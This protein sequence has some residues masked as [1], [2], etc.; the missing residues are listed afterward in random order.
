MGFLIKSQDDILSRAIQKIQS[1]TAITSVAPGSIMRSLIEAIAVEMGDLYKVV[2]FN[3]NLSLVSTAQGRALDLMAELYGLRR[4]TLGRIASIDA[5]LGSFYFYTLEAAPSDIV[6][7]AGTRIFTDSTNYV[8]TSFTYEL[9]NPCVIPAGRTRAYG[10]IKPLF[11]DSIFTAGTHT[12][13][14]HN[15]T[16]VPVGV[17][18]RCTNPKVIPAQIGYEDD[19][20]FRVRIIKAVRTTSGGT[21]EAVRFALLGIPGVRD[22]QI[23]EASFGLGTFEAIVVIESQAQAATVLTAV[24]NELNRVRP[25]GVAAF[26]KEPIKRPVDVTVNVAIKSQADADAISKRVDI[27]ILRYLNTFLI[28]TELSLSQLIQFVFEAAPDVILDVNITKLA[29]NGREVL[30]KNYA[31]KRDEILVPGSINIVTSKTQQ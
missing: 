25:V 22:V 15:F 4:K 5:S 17:T 28:G 2:D 16:D 8:G 20:S 10:T 12:L 11:A 26:I 27:A 9:V 29:V 1:D 31:P 14:T 6:I 7:P 3:F 21:N 18:L 19:D 13:K 30:R 24:T 23:Q